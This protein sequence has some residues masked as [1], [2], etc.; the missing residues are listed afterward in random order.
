MLAVA[1]II[2]FP[3]LTRILTVE[4]Y[5]IMNMISMVLI[6]VIAFSKLGIQNSVLRT[7]AEVKNNNSI[8]TEDNLYATVFTTVISASILACG[9]TASAAYYGWLSFF[10]DDTTSHYLL[11]AAIL[12]VIRVMWTIG[13]NVLVA[14]QRSKLMARFSILQ[15]YFALVVIISVL[16]LTTTG[17]HGYYYAMIGSETLILALLM[18]VLLKGINYKP[19]AF[20]PDLLK[21]MAKYGLPLLGLEIANSILSLG[22][23]LIISKYLGSEPLGAYS[24]AYNLCTYIQLIIIASY[25]KAVKPMYMNTFEAEGQAATKQL[26]DSA[27]AYYVMAALPIITILSVVAPQVLSL[28][29]S[30]KYDA[31][32]I[33]IPW[34]VSGLVVNG[35]VVMICAGLHLY[36]NTRIFMY[37]MIVSAV[38]NIGLNF[39]FIPKYG[40]LG[41]ALTTL[42][43][44]LVL[45]TIIWFATKPML[46]VSIPVVPL[47]KYIIISLSIYL[48]TIQI[49][50][51]NPIATML[52]RVAVSGVLFLISYALLDKRF[53]EL[54]GFL[55]QKFLNKNAVT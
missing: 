13:S 30:S 37:A 19:S 11:L 41:A 29:A 21:D 2:S 32:A 45:T 12:I 22:D 15:R 26:L 50:F 54:M 49:E 23:R 16:L 31:G 46:Q 10:F 36:K 48:G 14:H 44:Y 7:Y 5:G 35:A 8:Y 17:L 47:I 38:V 28:L 55:N 40:I 27:L 3:I 1:G 53:R 34:V 39:I 33:I 9:L 52:A 42:L 4:E 6:I 18:F 43:S 25:G 51:E 24:A 20:S